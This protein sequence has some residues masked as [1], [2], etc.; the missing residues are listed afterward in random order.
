VC[1]DV[2]PGDERVPARE[3]VG[4]AAASE[5]EAEELIEEQRAAA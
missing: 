3:T 4:P 5:E 2:L 1:R